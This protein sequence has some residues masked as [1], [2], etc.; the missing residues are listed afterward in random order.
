MPIIGTLGADNR[1]VPIIGNLRYYKT[2]TSV[3]RAELRLGNTVY[4]CNLIGQCSEIGRLI[5]LWRGISVKIMYW[6]AA[7]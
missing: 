3:Q 4:R 2:A 6:S 5:L 1:Y 7:S